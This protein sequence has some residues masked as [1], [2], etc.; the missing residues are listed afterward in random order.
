MN[1]RGRKRYKECKYKEPNYKNQIK[2][3]AVADKIAKAQSLK[4]EIRSNTK[5]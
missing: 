5:K 3:S 4:S 1:W 2:L